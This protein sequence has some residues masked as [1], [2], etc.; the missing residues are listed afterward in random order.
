[1]FKH[2]VNAILMCWMTFNVVKT[3][4]NGLINKSYF[5]TNNVKYKNYD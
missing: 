5:E 3:H 4:S 1:M 2:T